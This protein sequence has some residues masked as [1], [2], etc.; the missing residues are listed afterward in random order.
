S[1]PADSRI[2]PKKR[3]QETAKP[4]C[5]PCSPRREGTAELLSDK[6]RDA[7]TGLFGRLGVAGLRQHPNQRLSARWTHE[8]AALV[9]PVGVPPLDLLLDRRRKFPALDAD[10]LLHLRITVHDGRD[11]RERASLE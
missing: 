7:S 1:E 2:L 3:P 4:G 10:V 8:N 5:G 11:L 9:A 6:G